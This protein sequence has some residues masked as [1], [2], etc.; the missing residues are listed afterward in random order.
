VLRL[1]GLWTHPEDTDSFERDYLGAVVSRLDE[2]P[3]LQWSKTV[4]CI[5]GP[6]FPMTEIGY[7]T[8]DELNG[9]I[10]SE[11]GQELSE[12]ARA[13]AEKYGIRLDVVV[14]ADAS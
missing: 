13:L 2:L 1:I 6:Y 4:R 8:L 10:D 7:R 9:D 5:Y 11:L 14:V 12:Q 3:R